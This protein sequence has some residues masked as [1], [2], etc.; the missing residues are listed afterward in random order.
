MKFGFSRK[1]ISL[2]MAGALLLG[3][4][5]SEIAEMSDEQQAQ[6]G[7]YA[8]FAMLRYD[9]DHRSRLVDYSEVEAADEAIRRAAEAAAAAEEARQTE[10]GENQNSDETLDAGGNPVDVIDNT[11]E[12]AGYVSDTMEDFLELP[13]GVLLTYRG[14]TIQSSYPEDSDVSDYFVVDATNGNKFLV[15]WYTI[16]NGS[17]SDTEVN[18]LAD[19][20]AFKCRVN[21]SNTATALVTML[22]DDMSTLQTTMRDNDEMDCVLVFEINSEL[23]DNINSIVVK[24]SKNGADWERKVL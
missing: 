11:G 4:C 14:Y 23:A 1:F 22:D 16:Y 9:A 19:N 24:M 6:V 15:L 20:I 2:A 17:G 18:F 7:E 8:A 5:G 12:Q 21:D 3:G 10:T 13:S